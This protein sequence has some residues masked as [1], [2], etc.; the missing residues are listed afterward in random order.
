MPRGDAAATPAKACDIIVRNAYV[1]TMDPKRRVFA[2]GAIAIGG[3]TILAVGSEREIVAGYRAART[4]DA[5]GGVVHPGL[6]DAHVHIVHGTCRGIFANTLNSASQP[7]SFA[8]WKADVTPEDEHVATQLA[9]I[10]MLRHGYTCF[11]EPGTAFDGDAVAEAAVSLGIRGLLSGPYIWDDIGPMRHLGGLD[12]QS[13]YGRVPANL[14]RCL[15]DMGRELHRNRDDDALVRGYV[16]VYGLGTASD[17]LLAE[18]KA[19][20]DR[21]RVAFHQ[22]EGYLPGATKA[23]RDRIGKSRIRH[24]ADLGVLGPNA[25]LIHMYVLGEDDIAPIAE[26]GTSVVWCPV[27]FFTLGI[28]GQTTLR[29][30]AM[31]QLGVNLALGVD[32]AVD[33]TIGESG[34]AAF[35]VSA[36]TREPF[37]PETILEMQTINAARA[38][39]LAERIGSLEPGKRADLVIRSTAAA[40]SYPAVNPIHQLV[41]TSRGGSVDTVIV[42]GRVVMRGGHSTRLDELAVLAAARASVQR[43]M[44]RLGLRPTTV[45]PVVE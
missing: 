6:I 7:V 26:T 9:G 3:R 21:E 30:P 38:A 1:V 25:T 33:A 40:E 4:F 14:D 34:T 35:F 43:R 36:C 24:L 10:E 39:G 23:D 8:D 32:G 31:H 19:L 29:F 27:A 42:D 44:A 5:G 28:M 37:G 16:G 13:L 15:K 18:A 45:W 11:I 2:R 17:R 41:L 22:H 20:A 12:S